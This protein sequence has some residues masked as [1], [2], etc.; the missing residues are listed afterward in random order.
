M[1]QWLDN[2]KPYRIEN[3]YV[4]IWPLR[5]EQYEYLKT[6]TF[7]VNPDQL[8]F[9]LLGTEYQSASVKTNPT[10]T[11]F[12]SGCGQLAAL[13]GNLGPDIP[14]AI[15][16]AADIA[17]RKHLPP[18]SGQRERIRHSRLVSSDRNMPQK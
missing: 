7:L 13:F 15:I 14:K 17:M 10:I 16:G 18:D 12:G 9:L 8:S 6:I 2:Q 5:D 3:G 1:K 11:T 4:V